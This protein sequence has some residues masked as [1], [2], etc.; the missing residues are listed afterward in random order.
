MEWLHPLHSIAPHLHLEVEGGFIR[1][2]R[3]VHWKSKAGS[4]FP[5]QFRRLNI[6]S[7]LCR[8]LEEAVA[9]N[10]QRLLEKARE[11]LALKAALRASGIPMPRGVVEVGDV[12]RRGGRSMDD[13]IEALEKSEKEVAELKM[14]CGEMEKAIEEVESVSSALDSR[15]S[16]QILVKDKVIFQRRLNASPSSFFLSCTLIPSFLLLATP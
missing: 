3:Q 12:Q 14:V 10:E 16:E 8:E 9:V 1:S 5:L 2:R 15:L 6:K 4:R 11:S 13:L 7:P